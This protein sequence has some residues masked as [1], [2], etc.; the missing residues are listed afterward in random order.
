MLITRILLTGMGASGLVLAGPVRA[1]DTEES[2][3]EVAEPVPVPE[4]WTLR[5]TFGNWGVLCNED[6]PPECRAA[7]S[8]NYTDIE[9]PGRLLQVVLAVDAGRT[10]AVMTLPFGVDLQAG[11]AIKVDD[12]QEL[13]AAFTTCFPDG[14][15]SVVQLD[16]AAVEQ[17]RG[18]NI[19]KVGFRPWGG[20][21][22]TFVIDVP[23]DG[24][25]EALESILQ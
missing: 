1:N 5:S 16:E 7:Q 25:R 20:D 3:T 11:I 10:F 18:G 14:C 23:L 19:M 17:I 6:N 12:E 22:R 21:E 15:Q 2:P 8:Q 24:A 13:N 9:N 4:E